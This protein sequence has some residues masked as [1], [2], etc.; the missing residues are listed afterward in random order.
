[1]VGRKDAFN[2]NAGNLVKWWTENPP[3]TTSQY[4]AQ[5]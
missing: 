1:M 3:Q 5:P 2:W 4:L